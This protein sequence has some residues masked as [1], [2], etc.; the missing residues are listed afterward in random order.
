[1]SF[2]LLE[3][4]HFNHRLFNHELSNSNPIVQKFMVEM[5]KVEN[6]WESLGLNGLGLRWPS[7][8]IKEGERLEKE[9]DDNQA[10]QGT[11][12]TLRNHL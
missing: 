5:S 3:E 8:A 12:H 10:A 11:I 4:W 9:I 1:M 7:T 6:C 2:N